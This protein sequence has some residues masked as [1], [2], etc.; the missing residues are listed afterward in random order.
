MSFQL[1]TVLLSFAVA[2]AAAFLWTQFNNSIRTGDF[3]MAFGIIGFFGGIVQ[4]VVGLFLLFAENKKYAQS[5]LISGGLLMLIG[6]ATCTASF[7]V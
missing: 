2:L 6:F 1:K 4:L 3:F 5:F 7:R